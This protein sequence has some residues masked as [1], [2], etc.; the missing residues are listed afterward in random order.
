[1]NNPTPKTKRGPS[2]IKP[3]S[4]ADLMRQMITAKAEA[5]GFSV[6]QHHGGFPRRKVYSVCDNMIAKGQMFKAARGK[7]DVRL[8]TTPEAVAEYMKA[9]PESKRT[10]SVAPKKPAFSRNVEVV[11]TEKTKYTIWPTPEPRFSV[12][13]IPFNHGH[14]R[15]M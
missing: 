9:A 3:G 13:D 2:R 14:M 4:D 1:M 7:N 12:V 6:A 15:A 10:V 11:F 8:F 5:E